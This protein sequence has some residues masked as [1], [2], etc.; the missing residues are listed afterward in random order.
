MKLLVTLEPDE[1]GHD[2]RGVRGD[3]GLRVAGRTEAE[4]LEN[5]RE[6]IV[7]CLEAREANEMPLGIAV[8]GVEVCSDRDAARTF[9]R[10]GFP[11]SA[12]RPIPG[13]LLGP[14]SRVHRRSIQL[15]SGPCHRARFELRRL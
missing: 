12:S 7:G 15:P 6:A 13:S 1:T 10:A 14:S 8:R 3:S 4:V 2:R 9:A 11:A 5:V